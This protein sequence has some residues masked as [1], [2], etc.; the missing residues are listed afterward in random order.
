MMHRAMTLTAVVLTVALFALGCG[1][2][3]GNTLAGW[4]NRPA[5]FS[6]TM[7]IDSTQGLEF[8]CKRTF[9]DY[10]SNPPKIY[11]EEL[12]I[13]ANGEYFIE[14]TQICKYVNGIPIPISAPELMLH[15]EELQQGLGYHAV[16]HRGFH[17][18]DPYLFLEN[19]NYTIINHNAQYL[20][21]D[22]LRIRITA[23]YPDRPSYEVWIDRK[24][25]LVM[26]Y[27][28]DTIAVDPLTM[29]EITEIDFT[30]HFSG[31]TFKNFELKKEEVG[32]NIGFTLYRPLF[33]PAGYQATTPYRVTIGEIEV[34]RWSYTDGVQEIII[35]EYKAMSAQGN[36]GNLN[37]E[38]VMGDIQNVHFAV[39]AGLHVTYF[40][41]KDTTIMI[42]A[43]LYEE[44]IAAMIESFVR[45]NL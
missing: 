30:P 11:Y 18:H 44:E 22:A 43:N 26:K 4:M 37:P 28:E 7:P 25:S 40:D 32:Q 10:S 33:Y 42:K 8:M 31:I 5:P 21:R 34:L 15:N 3:S 14:C 17:I 2:P 12:W 36:K 39:D 13:K 20:G 29:M 41:F 35:G 16:F 27:I 19:Y 38:P 1:R 45:V 6:N 23:K 24:T 9:T